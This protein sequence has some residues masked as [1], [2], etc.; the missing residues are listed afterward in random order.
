MV[1]RCTVVTDVQQVS[2]S[3]SREKKKRCTTGRN[4]CLK[5]PAREST[6]ATQRYF[7][8]GTPTNRTELRCQP[9]GGENIT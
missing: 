4:R 8:D 6:D 3:I 9:S 2:F 1:A 5:R 7:H